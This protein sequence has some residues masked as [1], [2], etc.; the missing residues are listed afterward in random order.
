MAECLVALGSNLSDRG[1]ILRHAVTAIG[2]VAQTHLVARSHWHETPPVGGPPGQGAFLN[3]AVLVTTSLSSRDLYAELA[4]VEAKLGRVRAQRWA[5]RTIDLDLL[6][7]GDEES[8]DSLGFLDVPHPRMQSRRFALAPAADVAP[9]MVHPPSGWT[10]AQL[11]RQL[12]AGDNE[13]A[14]AGAEAAVVEALVASLNQ[15]L[16]R[17][18]ATLRVRRWTGG[19][20]NPG[21]RALMAVDAPTGTNAATR[22]KMLSLPEWGPVTWLGSNSVDDLAAE[23]WTLL[24][25]ASPTLAGL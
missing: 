12:D 17:G 6:L 23:A 19:A 2:R 4:G 5:A 21:P 7:H 14:I 1:A 18:G 3:G 24:A 8:C 25:S 15:R 11:L 16:E 10:V 9:W 20:W 13:A 22:R